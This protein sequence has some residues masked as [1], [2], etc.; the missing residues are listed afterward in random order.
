MP[1]RFR[2]GVRYWKGAVAH[3][4]T[5]RGRDQTGNGR[6]KEATSPRD[7]EVGD[8]GGQTYRS[9]HGETLRV[10]TFEVGC[11][12]QQL[13]D[14][15][16]RQEVVASAARYPAFAAA[17]N[18]APLFVCLQAFRHTYARLD[19]KQLPRRRGGIR[20]FHAA[21]I[22]AAAFAGWS[23]PASDATPVGFTRRRPTETMVD[24]FIL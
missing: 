11:D 6:L 8:G 20:K 19:A 2:Q 24:G 13:S 14:P 22:Q 12:R 5:A 17:E 21:E 3:G 9:C 15:S 7:E 23:C 1:S 4:T 10:Q 16:R 18:N